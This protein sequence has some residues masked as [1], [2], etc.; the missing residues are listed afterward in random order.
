MT[1]AF[2]LR[3]SNGLVMAADSRMSSIEGSSDTSTKFLQINREVGVMTYGLA[4]VGYKA[5]DKLNDEINRLKDFTTTTPKRIVYFS[6]ILEIAKRVFSETFNEWILDFNKDGA[7][8]DAND[9]TIQVGF[10][11]GGYDANETNQFQIVQFNSPRF[12]QNPKGDV[13]AAQN[14]VSR[15]LLKQFYYSEMNVQQLTKLAVFMLIETEMVTPS[16]GGRFQIAKVTVD[17][18]LEFLSEQDV[19]GIINSS[20]NNFSEYRKQILNNLRTSTE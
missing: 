16:V 11:L 18:G 1:L 10:L 5:I 7:N 15:Y 12:E 8:L 19:Q 17:Q 2:A 3:G 9:P 20:Q 4:E 13:V 14:Q 6:E